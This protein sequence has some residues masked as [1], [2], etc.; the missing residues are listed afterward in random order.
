MC[1]ICLHVPLTSDGCDVY[2]ADLETLGVMNPVSLAVFEDAG[3]A[4]ADD[5]TTY[6]MAVGDSFEGTLDSAGDRDRI[7]IDLAAGDEVVIS[8]TGDTLSDPYL[9]LYDDTGTVV[10][11]NDD[12]NSSYDSELTFSTTTGGTFYIEAGSYADQGTGTYVVEVATAPPFTPLEALDWGRGVTGTSTDGGTIDVFFAPSGYLFDDGNGTQIT[13]EGFNDYEIGQFQAA[14]DLYESYLNIDF[15]IVDTAAE[16]KFIMVLD[17]DEMASGLLGFFYLPWSGQQHGV[18]NGASWDRTAG[19]SLEQ[20]GMGFVTIVHEIG[21][22][23]G[24]TH[25]FDGTVLPGVS[26]AYDLGDFDLNQGLF[27]TMAYAQGYQAGPVGT[28]YTSWDYGMQTGPMGLDLG[29]LQSYYGA[30]AQTNAGDTLYELPT[31][32]ASGTFWQAIWDAGGEDTIANP[33]AEDSVID[34][35]EA[36]LLQEE[37]GGGFASAVDGIQGGFTIA[38]GAQI[39]HAQGGSG[40]DLL[41][42]NDAANDLDGGNGRDSVN[43]EAGD[44][45]LTGSGGRDRLNGDEGDD[46]LNGG[47]GNDTVNGGNG[48]DLVRGGNGNDAAQGGSGDDKVQGGAGDDTVEGRSGNDYLRGNDGDDTLIGGSGDDTLKGDAGQDIF[49][50]EDGFG[51]D[52]IVDF[53]A[54]DPGEKIDLSGVTEITD[55]TDLTGAHMTQ[56]GSHVIIDDGLG[57]TIR[58]NNTVLSDLTADDF[59]F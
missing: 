48:A 40:R 18:F 39:E 8:L 12:A 6:S 55:F 50:F 4:P 58:V 44:D 35:R 16:A 25:P 24:L 17:T 31:A 23:L 22:G 52:R 59:L 28:S 15:N 29:V 19:G 9:R 13:G 57:N 5:S 30:N 26:G 2:N 11:F 43:G 51:A 47:S 20:G 27:T 56:S 7:A 54:A 33:G 34:L 10:S 45:T 38:N 41:Q 42:G 53:D 21:H 49:V 36:T 3:D 37:G 14:F 46:T 32:N 1:M